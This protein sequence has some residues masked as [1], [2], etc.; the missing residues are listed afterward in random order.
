LT[1]V[2]PKSSPLFSLPLLQGNIRINSTLA[3]NVPM[4]SRNVEALGFHFN[5]IKILL[6]SHAHSDHCDGSARVKRLTGAQFYAMDADVPVVESG[7]KAD[8]LDGED[9]TL[10]FA[11]S[12]VDRLL[13]DNDT[14]R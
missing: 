12:L 3:E 2:V 14:V 4:I 11:P 10:Y 1:T 13:R 5:D 6:I 9:P 8:V 7:G